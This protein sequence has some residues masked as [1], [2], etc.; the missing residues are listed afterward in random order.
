MTHT[1]A[2]VA[3]AALLVAVCLSGPVS[4]ASAD[5]TDA[6]TV[7]DGVSTVT[8]ATTDAVS[9]TAD[10]TTD[11]VDSTTDAVGDGDLV[12]GTESVASGT[13]SATV[14]GSTDGSVDA[15]VSTN[16]TAG[17]ETAASGTLTL[18][19]NGTSLQ[20]TAD[21]SASTDERSLDASATSLLTGEA[22][23]PVDATVASLL[24]HSDGGAGDASSAART[25]T[26]DES[27][28]D[29]DTAERASDTSDSGGSSGQ[30]GT[31]RPG[32]PTTMVGVALVGGAVAARSGLTVVGASPPLG[33]GS[34]ASAAVD[35][36]RARLPA[37]LPFGYSRHDDSDPLEHEVRA[38]L[39]A[40]IEA[41]PGVNLTALDER[42]DVSLSSVRHH[43]RILETEALV[44]TD[45]I[46]GKRR[47][48]PVGTDDA[49]LV[50]ALDDPAK[51]AVLRAI[52]AQEPASVSD[53]ADALDRDPSTVSHHL[54][55]LAADDL[56]ERE[57]VGQS[58]QTTLA[59]DVRPAV[60]PTGGK[61][62]ATAD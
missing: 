27:P 43:L 15:T 45:L 40:A 42:V 52:A 2:D 38:D 62:G 53:L 58:V 18:A 17:D 23:P 35:G 25:P 33:L 31:S 29:A 28:G 60:E 8:D 3:L 55:Q 26:D 21:A 46:N 16:G 10:S 37:F 50:A 14:N 49:V 57:R 30:S 1:L 20:A 19:A 7:D 54:S 41:T 24:A 13:V 9:E 12:P 48:F 39:Y 32:G 22:P 59:P 51:A 56:V 47:Y 4:A 44:E 36:L 11:A 34:T 5:L 6:D 61:A